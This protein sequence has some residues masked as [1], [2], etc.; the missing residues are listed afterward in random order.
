[1][2]AGKLIL[3]LETSCDETSAAVVRDGRVIL[4]NVIASQVELHA[5]YGGVVPEL[6]SRAHLERLLP[7]IE[8]ALTEARVALDDLDAIAVTHG[9][10]LIGALLTGLTCAKALSLSLAVPLLAVNHLEAHIYANFLEHPGLEPPL[11]AL[12]VSGGHTMIAYM[13]GHRTYQLL[14]ETLDDAAGEAFD[15]IA[16]F[17]D[18][19]YPGG[20]VIDR[21]SR[22]GD[23]HAIRFPRAMLDDGTY[24]FS[25][26]GLKT[27]VINYV[28]KAR[29]RGEELVLP[30]LVASFQEAVVEVQVVKTLRAA[31]EK[32][33]G[34]VVLAG[35]VASNL[36][37]RERL[38]AALAPQGIELLFP[39][40][41]LCM[42]NA[43][44]VASL[45]CRMLAAGDTAG[46]DV[47]ARSVLPL[48]VADAP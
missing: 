31:R 43:A 34:R 10:G 39:S 32:G 25:L 7:V 36:T 45:A 38:A 1:M 42:D 12:L 11:V 23:P 30:D 15:K 44:M 9:P 35:G 2:D 27:A 18:L 5:R 33:V 16:R 4:S 28:R 22:E 8:E 6:A 14:G 48:P 29:D 41:E 40:R 20:P 21:L 19:G 37:L 13:P 3:G 24:N 47:E 17:L 46:L 26:S